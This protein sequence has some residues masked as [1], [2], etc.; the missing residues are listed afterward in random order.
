MAVIGSGLRAFWLTVL[1]AFAGVAH[2]DFSGRVVAILDGDTI[3]VLVDQ[4]PVRVRLA[5]IDAPEKRQAFGTRSRQLLAELVYLKTVQVWEASKSSKVIISTGMLWFSSAS[6]ACL[7]KL[8]VATIRRC[9]K[10]PLPD[11]VKKLPRSPSGI[12]VS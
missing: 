5:Q 3:D 4:R 1:L 10:P 12:G 7:L 11:K 2:A 9:V 6:A 8:A